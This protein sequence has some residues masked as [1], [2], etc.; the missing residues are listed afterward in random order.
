MGTSLFMKG[1]GERFCSIGKMF[2]CILIVF[3]AML[4]RFFILMEGMGMGLSSVMEICSK[5]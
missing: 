3:E 4:K 2:D 5:M 1:K